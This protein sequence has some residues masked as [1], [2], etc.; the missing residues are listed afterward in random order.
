MQQCVLNVLMKNKEHSDASKALE[1]Q[2]SSI[3]EI[4]KV[5]R[6]PD[7]LMDRRATNWWSS[8]DQMNF[9]SPQL[10][11]CCPTGSVSQT[12]MSLMSEI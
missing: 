10:G 9:T 2:V 8:S 3:L 12:N 7:R 11:R 6:I 4:T 1:I 5:M